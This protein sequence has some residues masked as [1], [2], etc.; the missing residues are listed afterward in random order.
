[1]V[2]RRPSLAAV[3]YRRHETVAALKIH[4]YM[5]GIREVDGFLHLTQKLVLIFNIILGNQR[6]CL[7]GRG[8]V[9]RLILLYSPERSA[10]F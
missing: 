1:M 4:L 9:D 10:K 3:A 5:G 8:F 7:L 2:D 6:N